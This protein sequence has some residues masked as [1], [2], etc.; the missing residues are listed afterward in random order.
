MWPYPLFASLGKVSECNSLW[1]PA[2]ETFA[3]YYGVN[4]LTHYLGLAC[5]FLDNLQVRQVP[6]SNGGERKKEAV[7]RNCR[8]VPLPAVLVRIGR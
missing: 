3:G 6:S 8:P 7:Q 4:R 1:T 2:N 5:P